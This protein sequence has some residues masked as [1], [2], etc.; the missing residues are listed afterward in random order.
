MRVADT[1]KIEFEIGHRLYLDEEGAA[2][3][4]VFCSAP[5]EK[6]LVASLPGRIELAVLD[7][8][9]GRKHQQFRRPEL[10]P[11]PRYVVLEGRA[12]RE[13]KGPAVIDEN[14]VAS[15]MKLC[16]EFVP[17]RCRCGGK[18]MP[19]C[20]MKHGHPIS[21]FTDTLVLVFQINV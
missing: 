2:I 7:C 16:D 13:S 3:E 4:L 5:I 9:L 21:T 12:S 18:R 19:S 14:S 20:A 8:S 11:F 17:D 1:P 10:V 6:E 15:K